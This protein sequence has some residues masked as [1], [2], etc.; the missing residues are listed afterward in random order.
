MTTIDR[1]HILATAV[2]IARE[3][4]ALL[5]EGY[6]Q[7]KHIE[8]KSSAVDWVTQYDKA[9]E[10]LIVSRLKRAFPDHGLVG[11]EGTNTG[12]SDGFRWYIDP[13]DGTGNYA[14]NFPMFCVS[15][16]LYYGDDPVL[17]VICDPVHQEMFTAVAGEGAYLDGPRGRRRLEVTQETDLAAGLLATGFPYDVHTSPEN[18]LNY[19]NLFTRRAQGIRR[20]G[21][22]ALDVAYVAAGRLDGYWELKVYCWDMSAAILMVQEAGGRVTFLDGRPIRL[23]HRFDILVSNGRLHQQMLDIVAEAKQLPMT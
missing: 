23:E 15:M 1:Q 18:N 9:S 3:A 7:E 14:H 20:P 21:S 11:E 2:E 12:A 22:A 5:M 19:V 4:G 10:E 17:G 16:G 8:R 6:G 13:L